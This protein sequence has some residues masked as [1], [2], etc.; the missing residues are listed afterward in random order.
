MPIQ[1]YN[2]VKSAHGEA[3]RIWSAANYLAS[4][5]DGPIGRW[6]NRRIAKRYARRADR[7]AEALGLV[8]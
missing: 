7:L 4:V 8:D 1:E 6:I 5:A 2:R 3:L